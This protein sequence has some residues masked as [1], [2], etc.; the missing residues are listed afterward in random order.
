MHYKRGNLSQKATRAFHKTKNETVTRGVHCLRLMNLPLRHTRILF[1][2]ISTLL[3]ASAGVSRAVV[4]SSNSVITTDNVINTLGDITVSLG[5]STF[6]NHGLVGVGRVSASMLDQFGD[7][8]GSVSGLQITNWADA[9][10]GSY[11][12][13]FNTLP[14]R[15]Y[16]TA[17]GTTNIFADYAG[18]IEQLSFVFTPYTGLANIGGTTLEQ[19]AAAQNQIQATYVGGVKFTY[20]TGS[21]LGVTTGL[22]PAVGA[23]GVLTTSPL[24]ATLPMGSNGKLTLDAEALVLKQDGSGYIGDEY[25][26]NIYHFD[27]SKKIDAVLPIPN[28]FKP[29]LAGITS[30]DALGAPTDGRRNNQGFEGVSMSPDGTKLF[31]LAQSATVQ[32]TGSGNQGRLNTRLLTYDL[33]GGAVPASPSGEYVLRLPTLTDGTDSNVPGVNKTAA[34]SEIVALDSN[35]FLVL[36]RDS[37]GAGIQPAV[38]AGNAVTN[39]PPKF[40]SV[41]LVDLTVAGATDLLGVVGVNE[42]GEKITTTGTTLKPGITPLS[43]TEAINL[44]NTDQLSRFNIKTDNYSTP[45]IL[46]L[47]EKWEGMSIVSALDPFNPNDYFIFIAN[48]NDFITPDGHMTLFDGTNTTTTFDAIANAN[49]ANGNTNIPATFRNDTMFLA[50]RVTIVPEPASISLFGSGFIA[51]IARRRRSSRSAGI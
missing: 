38:T 4:D 51:L 9:G 1:V 20:D 28:A 30:Y 3:F 27:S 6:I 46:T 42:A 23:P 48:D 39:V 43:W 36:S 8:F 18:R 29:R 2:S 10:G 44:L 17:V 34:Q 22:N 41:L 37:N 31:V 11:T 25:G 19:K 49:T 45:D 50:Y 13:V 14:D 33:T 47:S 26:A 40:K 35:R 32:D 16:N 21:G 5:G 12:G 15:G 7:T 24:A